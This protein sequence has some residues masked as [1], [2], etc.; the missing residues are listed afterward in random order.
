[1]HGDLS[2]A[3]PWY[4]F[5]IESSVWNFYRLAQRMRVRKIKFYRQQKVQL[6]NFF[7]Y[8]FQK[9]YMLVA[10]L[11][12][13]DAFL[14]GDFERT[15]KMSLEKDLRKSIGKVSY[16][17]NRAGEMAHNGKEES[18]QNYSVKISKSS[19]AV[20]GSICDSEVN[21]VI[22]SVRELLWKSGNV[23]FSVVFNMF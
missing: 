6:Y 11:G 10:S 15:Q 23:I 20:L 16:F 14:E 13:L 1:M 8:C 18:N 22:K 9:E 2:C 12:F 19:R 3:P 17:S 5:S 21:G 7:P 4:S